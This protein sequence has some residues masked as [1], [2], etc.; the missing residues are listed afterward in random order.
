MSW[1]GVGLFNQHLCSAPS[2]VILLFTGVG[3]VFV[4]DPMGSSGRQSELT[5]P[6]GVRD[7]ESSEGAQFL[8][9]ARSVAAKVW[10]CRLRLLCCCLPQ[11]EG[12][13]AAF[14]SI[15]QLFSDFFSVRKL[16]READVMVKVLA[17]TD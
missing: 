8:S 4:F 9:T 7:M 16:R 12:H 2:W 15:S 10:E 5:E 13:R 1:G 3:V 6:L 17:A 14:A 11:D